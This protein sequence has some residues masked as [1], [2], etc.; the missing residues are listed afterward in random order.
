MGHLGAAIRQLGDDAARGLW[1]GGDE[2]DDLGRACAVAV[3]QVR[4]ER[5]LDT[6]RRTRPHALREAAE[7]AALRQLEVGARQRHGAGAARPE[8]PLRVAAAQALDDA[9]DDTL[10][11]AAVRRQLTAPER[12]HPRCALEDLLLTRRLRRAARVHRRH[13]RS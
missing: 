9:I 12:Q 4:H 13:E 6:R 5:M 7:A 1:V 2:R 10:R 3:K 11:D 8:A